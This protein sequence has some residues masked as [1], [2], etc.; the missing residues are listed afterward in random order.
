LTKFKTET[1]VDS[2]GN[3]TEVQVPDGTEMMYDI[4]G[5]KPFT[6]TALIH[7]STLQG[8]PR[9][10]SKSLEK[11][12]TFKRLAPLVQLVNSWE[13]AAEEA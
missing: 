7:L 2:E 3:T 1:R 12:P 9:V 11:Q 8:L 13:L 5:I 4:T 10:K 6:L